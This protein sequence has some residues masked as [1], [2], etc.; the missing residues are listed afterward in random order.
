[1]KQEVTL[2]EDGKVWEEK[3]SP[4]VG[5]DFRISRETGVVTSAVRFSS[6]EKMRML[7]PGSAEHAF[8]GLAEEIG[9]F[10]IVSL[11]NTVDSFR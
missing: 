9:P 8:V 6:F 5:K 3:A 4:F 11:L 2:S 10:P 7:F 1:M